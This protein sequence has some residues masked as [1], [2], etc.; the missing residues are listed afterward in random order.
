M[1]GNH[2]WIAE[3]QRQEMERRL[4]R[5][6]M[7]SYTQRPLSE[8]QGIS[9]TGTNPD[10]T[11]DRSAP[12]GFGMTDG[13]PHVFHQGEVRVQTPENTL[14]LNAGI[15]P[16]AA[17][18]AVGRFMGPRRAM[19]GM[20]SFQAGGNTIGAPEQPPPIQQPVQPQQQTPAQQ[21][22]QPQP[23][24][25]RFVQPAINAARR[26]Q[27]YITQPLNSPRMAGLSKTV[28]GTDTGAQPAPP[29]SATP[30]MDT[31]SNNEGTTGQV[32]ESVVKIPEP[33]ILN[34]ER[35]A[36]RKWYN[37]GY[38]GGVSLDELR[39]QAKNRPW[40]TQDTDEV[41]P[42]DL[43]AN[44]QMGLD[45]INKQDVPSV[46]YD[47]NTANQ[48]LDQINTAWAPNNLR[49]A[50]GSYRINELR[51]Q[52]AEQQAYQQH[53]QAMR[54]TDANAAWAQNA[55]LQAQQDRGI[56]QFAAE[57]AFAQDKE[58]RSQSLDLASTLLASGDPGGTAE[59]VRIMK[60]A[61]PGL[62]T[63]AF[64]GMVQ[65]ATASEFLKMDALAGTMRDKSEADIAS[66]LKAA[67]G[68]KYSDDVYAGLAAQAKL[69]E[70]ELR[71]A[72]YQRTDPRWV[73]IQA[74]PR[75]TPK[76]RDAAGTAAWDWWLDYTNQDNL[77]GGAP[78][79]TALEILNSSGA[80]RGTAA[81]STSVEKYANSILYGEDGT[82]RLASS[83]MSSLSEIT[84]AGSR[85]DVIQYLVEKGAVK[86]HPLEE[87]TGAYNKT[88]GYPKL[89]AA[90]KDHNLVLLNVNGQMQLGR[91]VDISEAKANNSAN[92]TK[93]YTVLFEDGREMEYN[94]AD[95]TKKVVER[96]VK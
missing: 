21:Q 2:K 59:A 54:G 79:P 9:Y 66:A 83:L 20:P 58:T 12:A 77:T 34:P 91:V 74:M 42:L 33:T 76:E 17:P 4:Q 27:Q 84:D 90:H 36:K 43:N 89:D 92:K 68:N 56:N 40:Q 69:T 85:A 49:G 72:E 65:D 24:A 10:G 81:H 3:A 19:G 35:A 80:E 32:K 82:R 7:P 26:A 67:Y 96:E 29:T 11:V 87:R 88:Y 16:Q 48:Y 63:S 6:G 75:G 37:E 41:T 13:Q 47:P 25:P 14:Y 60:W 62:E 28:A 50:E 8:R 23:R 94:A 53:M 70:S 95:N 44:A 38:Q 18:E 57:Y 61:F 5:R 22:A 73:E 45:L 52:A 93:V 64:E 31:I 86:E 51:R 1:I 30:A 55:M 39:G 15:A 78:A 46:S 71:M